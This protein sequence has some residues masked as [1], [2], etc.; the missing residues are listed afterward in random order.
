MSVAGAVRARTM[1]AG[2]IK[3]LR[4]ITHADRS[5]SLSRLREPLTFVRVG[6]CLIFLARH[7]EFLRGVVELEHHGWGAGPEFGA[8]SLAQVL[9]AFVEPLVPRFDALLPY[10]DFLCR[11]RLALTFLLLVGVFPRQNAFLLASVSFALF[12]AD[13]LR[14]LHHLLLLYVSVLFLALPQDVAL[15]EGTSPRPAPLA[16]VT[17]RAHV[18]VVY[19]A[20]GLAKCAPAWL[21]GATLRALHE[22]HFAGGPVFEAGVGILGYAG[23]AFG[24][25]LVELALPL[26]FGFRRTRLLGFLV[27]L[28]LHAFI[29]QA[30]LVS[31]FGVTM[32]VLVGAFLPTGQERQDFGRPPLRQ[33]VLAGCLAA[34]VPLL[35]A[36]LSTKVGSYSMFTRLAFYKVE[37]TVDGR[38]FSRRKL[39]PH[40]GRDGAR[41]VI[42]GNGRGIGET[43]I[44]I[45]ARQLPRLTSF[46][47]AVNPGARRTQARLTTRRIEGGTSVEVVSVA[48]CDGAR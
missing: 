26:L 22:N 7:E 43:N 48:A 16:L 14:Y 5:V 25:C 39:A 21:S 17:L 23:L 31:T 27:A 12:A 8:Q 33:M 38:P 1:T 44:E 28:G 29:H 10:S 34:G 2:L 20:A 30:I 13:G 36:S 19:L 4:W 42:S 15:G 47:C 40:L 37:M 46:L 9:P 41:V 24:A 3:T 6:L 35:A 11:V 32:L 18:Q 45:L